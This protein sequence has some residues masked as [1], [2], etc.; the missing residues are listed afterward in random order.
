MTDG[1]RIYTRTGDG[2]QT[3]LG[4]GRRVAKTHP[5]VAA[6]GAV[7]EL[8]ALLGVCLSQPLPDEQTRHWLLQVQRDL[9][10]VGADLCQSSPRQFRLNESAV[11]RLESWIDQTSELLEPLAGF[12]LPGGSPAAAFLHLARAVCRR[13]ELAVWKLAQSEPVNSHVATYLNRLSDLLFVLARRANNDGR[14]DVLW[15]TPGQ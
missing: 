10:D 14:D 4:S 2:G 12:V 11:L 8:N 15:Q 7:D 13:A 9:L 5:A 1:R 3:S 6:G